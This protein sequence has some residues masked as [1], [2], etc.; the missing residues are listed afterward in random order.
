[1]LTKENCIGALCGSTFIDRNFN[2][3]M[4]K[5][6]GISYTSIDAEA[7]G[8]SSNF[9]RQFEAVKRGFTGPNHTRRMGVWPINM[10]IPKS[11]IYDKKNFTVKLQT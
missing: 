11:A 5:K 3:W 8:P 4:T 7:R 2:D 6:F 9:F 10:N 1:M